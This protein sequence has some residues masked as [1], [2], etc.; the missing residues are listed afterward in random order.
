MAAD[1]TVGAG[2]DP[3]DR[4]LRSTERWF[5]R[6]GLPMFVEDYSAGRDVWTRALPALVVLFL[7]MSIGSVRGE[8]DRLGLVLFFAVVVTF[9]VGYVA[10]NKRRGA[11]PWALPDT[12]GWPW[13][14]VF[15]GVTTVL[16]V[17]GDRTWDGLIGGLVGAVVVLALVYVVAR[18]ALVALTAWALRWTFRSLYGVTELVTRV[19][20]LMLLVLTF[21]YLSPGVWQAMG[22]SNAEAIAGTLAVLG[23]IGVLFTI[24]RA[25]KEFATVDH[26]LGRDDVL[27]AAAGTPLEASAPDLPDL[28]RSVPMTKKQRVNVHLVMVVAQLVQVML[29]G[30]VVWA[31]FVL[32]GAV[33]VRLPVQEQWL[34][35]LGGPQVM[36]RWGDGHALTAASIRVAAFLGGFAAFYATVYAA[37]DK[38]YRKYFAERISQDLSRAFAVRRAYLAARRSAGLPAPELD[39]V[40]TEDPT[41]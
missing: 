10:W 41:V 15:V 40:A 39:A 36:L 2:T 13:L 12:I 26:S 4:A 29:I 20:P 24:N 6:R 18:Y 31:F 3:P 11:K 7:L 5:I 35:D 25:R 23:V 34:K 27:Q 21:L 19:L 38:V 33:A 8:E 22:S 28:E 16:A 37:T 32:F 30:V 1:A 9:V 17:T 14:L